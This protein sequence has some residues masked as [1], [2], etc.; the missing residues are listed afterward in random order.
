MHGEQDSK[1]NHSG[2][3]IWRDSSGARNDLL[4]IKAAQKIRNKSVEGV[5]IIKKVDVE[6]TYKHKTGIQ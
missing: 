2:S 4:E 3:A 5:T 6:V 1:I